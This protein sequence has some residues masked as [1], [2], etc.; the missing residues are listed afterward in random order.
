MTPAAIATLAIVG[1]IVAALAFY[2]TWVAVILV[3]VHRNL[4]RTL[5]NLGTVA[6][7]AEPIGPVLDDV[8]AKLTTI[9]L[10]LEG[11]LEK[12]KPP[13]KAS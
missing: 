2:L 5:E 10:A 9:A 8:N 3:T 6:D 7:R 4:S 11:L 1:L 13:A 12:L